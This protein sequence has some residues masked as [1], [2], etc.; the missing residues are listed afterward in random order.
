[1]DLTELEAVAKKT[2]TESGLEVDEFSDD[3]EDALMLHDI[4][5]A[6]SLL[7]KCLHLFD[8]VGDTDLCKSVTKRERESMSR[9]SEQV[10]EFLDEVEPNYR[11]D[12]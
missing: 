9:L 8:Y 1:M 4:S 7:T 2:T 10:R 5:E 3:G 12:I 11:E 6:M